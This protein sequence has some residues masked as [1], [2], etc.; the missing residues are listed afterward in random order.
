MEN[1]T[2][3]EKVE[4]KMTEVA[5]T[6]HALE[7]KVLQEVLDFL[8]KKPFIEVNDLLNK[9]HST[10]KPVTLQE[11]PTPAITETIQQELPLET[12]SES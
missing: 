9:I 1:E 3:I 10:A 6:F 4:E 7:T 8:V 11:M 5:K 2:V 12:P